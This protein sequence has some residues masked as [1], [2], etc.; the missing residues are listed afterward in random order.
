VEKLE[1]NKEVNKMGDKKKKG[2][3]VSGGYHANQK[4]IGGS[5]RVEYVIKN[6]KVTAIPYV[7]GSASK[8]FKKGKPR[9][10]VD[11]IGVD[12]EYKPTKDSFIKFKGSTNPKRTNKQLGLEAGFTFKE[13]GMIIRDRQYLK[14][15]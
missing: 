5:G 4:G 11:R 1:L 7:S 6:E 2:L 8:S 3:G 14:G 15:K 9:A 13:G 10:S 12:A